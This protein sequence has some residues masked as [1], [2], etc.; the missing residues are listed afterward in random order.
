MSKKNVFILCGIPASGK[1]TW[2]KN[3][4]DIL[5]GNT[6]VV[7]RDKI[8]YSLLKNGDKYFSKEKEVYNIFIKVIKFGLN[9]KNINNIIIDATHLSVGSRRKLLISLEKE[10]K[11]VNVFGIAFSTPLDVCLKRNTKRCGRAKVPKEQLENMYKNFT[12]PK[13]DEGFD[14]IYIIK[15]LKELK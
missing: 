5:N 11:K 7:S 9:N 4:K 10:L 2:A 8:R 13:K 3:N 12:I 14:E 1:S 15:S 6:M